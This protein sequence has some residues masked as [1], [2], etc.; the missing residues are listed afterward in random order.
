MEARTFIAGRFTKPARAT[1][2]IVRHDPG[3]LR[4]IVSRAAFSA[5][6]VDDAVAAA[7]AAYP[8]WAESPIGFRLALLRRFAS[9]AKKE[10]ERIARAISLEIGKPL[11]ES[12]EEAAALAKKVEIT[13]K[14][15]LSLVHPFYGGGGRCRFHPRGVMAVIG[16]FNMPLHLPN[17]HIIPA[18]A[19]GNTVVFKPSELAPASATLYARLMQ[20]ARIPPGVFNLVQGDASVGKRLAAHES[21]SGVLF[22]GSYRAGLWIERTASRQPFKITALELGG[23]NAAVV[24]PDADLNHAIS[25]CALGAFMTTGQRCTSTSRIM[26]QRTILHRFLEGFVNLAHRLAIGHCLERGVFMGP[27]A[28]EKALRRFKKAA[29]QARAAGAEVLLASQRPKTRH[30]GHYIT[31]SVHLLSPRALTHPYAREE[32]FGPDVAVVPFDDVDEAIWLVNQSDYGLALSVF[33]GRSS[34]LNEFFWRCRV[35]IL[36]LNRATIGASS[37]LPFGGQGKSG[38]DRPAALYSPF[39]C[40]YP[41]ATLTGARWRTSYPPG[42]PHPNECAK[43]LGS[44]GG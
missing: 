3:A 42:F 37:E 14:R 43:P 19:T 16:P 10:K 40:T 13:I 36:N 29:R 35:G 18:L 22:T 23:K 32:I 5:E 30:E 17:G 38:N 2:E 11:W 6:A 33:T 7:S 9:L 4:R 34:V 20:Q 24:F 44:Q 21:V 41:V 39:Y 1:G 12:R 15:S 26:V 28:S 31:A 8:R 27:L 25:Q